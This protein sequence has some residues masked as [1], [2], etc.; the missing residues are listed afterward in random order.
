MPYHWL[1]PS[2]D[3][4]QH[5]HLTPHI[6]LQPKGFVT[7]IGVTVALMALPLIAVLGSP[8]LYGLL[9]FLALA[10]W[11]VWAAL[12]RNAAD[13][14]ITEDLR[15]T[16]DRMDLTRTGPR[17]KVQN[18]QANPYWVQVCLHPKGGPVPQYLTLQGGPREVEL[19]AFL[20]EPERVA[21]A[22]ELQRS[23][24]RLR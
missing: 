8:A 18:W 7:F 10:V 16:P 6:S 9:P 15:L 13:R 22:D 19:G 14:T 2:Q 24:A 3:A 12:R 23:L 21:L 17:G 4:A 1:P 5:L 11:G 20:S